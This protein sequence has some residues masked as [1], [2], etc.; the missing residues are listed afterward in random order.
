MRL[1]LDT[2]VF[3]WWWSGDRRLNTTARHSIARALEVFVSAASAWKLV[4]KL[5]LGKLRFEG[6]ISDAI[7]ACHFME[8]AV[9]TQHAE[10]V[11]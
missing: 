9:S 10:A 11:R 5:T 3:L 4:I 2:H 7:E 8:L 6:T 1:L